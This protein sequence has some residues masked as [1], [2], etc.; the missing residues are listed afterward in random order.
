MPVQP[1]YPGVYVQEVPSGVR[2]ITGVSTSVAAFVGMVNRGPLDQPTRILSF[3]DYER[4]FG[5]DTAVSEMTDQVRQFF[6]NGGQQAYIMRIANGAVAAAVT[7]HNES[8][9]DEV[10]QLTAKEAGTIGDAI[11]V[12]IDY[13][14][15]SPESTFNLTAYRLV[16]DG[17][18]GTERVEEEA[19]SELSM[20]PNSP[21]F[22]VSVLSQQS[23]LLNAAP[24]GGDVND[25]SGITAISFPGYSVAG[26]IASNTDFETAITDAIPAGQSGSFL[27]SVDGSP[28]VPVLVDPATIPGNLINGLNTAISNALL[29]FSVSA[30]ALTSEDHL[31]IQS[32]ASGGSVR[33]RSGATNDLSAALLLGLDRGGL[34]VDGFAAARPAPNGIFQRLGTLSP[35]TLGT[36]LLSLRTLGSQVVAQVTGYSLEDAKGTH[37]Q[38]ANFSFAGATLI[39]NAAGTQNSLAQL[40]QSLDVI[41][42]QI[43]VDAAN[44]DQFGW[45]AERIGF[46]IVLKPTFGNSDTMA[47]SFATTTFSAEFTRNVPAYRTNGTVGELQGGG[48]AGNDGLAPEA[49][50]Y[51]DAYVIIDR[52]VDLFNLLILPRAATQDDDTMAALY[53]TASVFCQE[54]RAFLIVDPRREWITV[55]DV[56]DE[57]ADVRIGL[58]TDIAAIYWPRLTISV[59]GS[60][61]SID[62]SG[63]IAGLMA[64]IDSSRGV[65]KAPAGTE[66]TIR[67]V[68]GVEHAMSDGEN[69][70]INPQAV[71][72][73]RVFPA[74]V[75]SWGAR[76]MVGFNNSGN[77][78]YKY[79]PVRRLALF[80]E[81]SL[82]RGLQFAVFEPNDEPLWAQIRLAAGAFMN[83]LFRQGAF[84]GQKASDAYFVKVDSETT[85]QNDINLGIVNVVVG[86]APLKPAEF[87]II[88][89]QQRAGQVSV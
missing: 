51:D 47:A 73:L 89:L 25:V 81:E 38:S 35:A 76:T 77:D 72:A 33:L 54:S 49:D 18:G 70:V 36:W 11:R 53:G 86:F 2:T 39:A 12:E 7:L 6:L 58:A 17:Q 75:V 60:T 37:T 40:Q 74:G 87:V 78:D 13:D 45:E 30:T 27:I 88:T 28:Y 69:G 68:R 32:S 41:V 9:L 26:L 20:N 5:N 34:E 1:T 80:M 67:G 42:N 23:N 3:A 14:T 57:I 64:R 31:I 52:E 79:V 61:R 84:Q 15:S 59:N 83:N 85:T 71:N 82:Y 19:L 4:K 16:S 44:D 46:R 48:T 22:A 63:S 29:N 21:R 55:D 24:P 65:W 8:G 66:A 62:P 43:N 56:E 50:E 10:L